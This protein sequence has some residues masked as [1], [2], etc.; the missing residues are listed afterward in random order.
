MCLDLYIYDD[1]Q[2]LIRTF[3]QEDCG[4][5]ALFRSHDGFNPVY[6]YIAEWD[7]QDN[8]GN[9]VPLGAY[10]A[11]ARFYLLYCP[12]IRVPFEIR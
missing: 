4:A 8:D 12:V 2:N 7:Q 9:A 11:V 10:T 6:N 1:Q 5:M 3:R